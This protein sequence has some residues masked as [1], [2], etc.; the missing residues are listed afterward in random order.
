MILYL[1]EITVQFT[2]FHFLLISSSLTKEQSLFE[3]LKCLMWTL[4]S[5]LL[6]WHLGTPSCKLMK[7]IDK[8]TDF[9]IVVIIVTWDD[10]VSQRPGFGRWNFFIGV[11]NW[12][13]FLTFPFP[14]PLA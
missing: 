5:R 9:P 8:S 10:A 13:V 1:L 7:L 11:A 4:L 12:H 3:I 2:V 14:V 6:A